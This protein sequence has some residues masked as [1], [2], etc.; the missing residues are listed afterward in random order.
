MESRLL[1]GLL[2]VAVAVKG[3]AAGWAQV[4]PLPLGCPAARVYA[5]LP[6]STISRLVEHVCVPPQ[7]EGSET[8]LERQLEREE[9]SKSRHPLLPGALQLETDETETW[10]VARMGHDHL[11]RLE[12]R[13]HDD[14]RLEDRARDTLAQTTWHGWIAPT[15]DAVPG[16]LCRNHSRIYAEELSNRLRPQLWALR[17]ADA[18]GKFPDGLLYGNTN[19]LGSWDGCRSV[20]VHLNASD[21]PDLAQLDFSGQV[22][23]A[24]ISSSPSVTD[25][26]SLVPALPI[27]A[28]LGLAPPAVRYAYCVPS[29]CDTED[30]S[31]SLTESLGGSGLTAT[32]SDC[33][34]EGESADLDAGDWALVVVLAL[35]A[36]TLLVCTALDVAA[37]HELRLPLPRRRSNPLPV[38]RGSVP[39]PPSRAGTLVRAFSLYDSVPRLLNTAKD[40][41]TIG[42]L[43]GIRFLTM[44]WIILGHIYAIGL[45]LLPVSNM[46]KL[47]E[48]IEPLPF[49]VIVN[50]MPA[51]DT[52]LVVS[53]AMVSLGLARE[54]GA[55]RPVGLRQLPALYL[56]RLLRLTPLYAAVIWFTA[57]LLRHIGSGTF[58][59]VN[60]AAFGIT[61]CQESWWH[62]L[63]YINNFFPN[64]E[65]V[66]I[67]QSWYLALDMQ[68]FLVAPLLV[69]PVLRW[70][71]AGWLPFGFI[72]LASVVIPGVITYVKDL[73]PTLLNLNRRATDPDVM[74][75]FTLL[76]Y[77][78]PWSRAAPYLIGLALGLMLVDPEPPK[79]PSRLVCGLLWALS[80]AVALLVVLGMWKYN[81]EPDSEWTPAVAV[82]YAALHRPAWGLCIAWV[83]WAC[84]KGRGGPVNALLSHPVW[85]PLS[86][87][88]YATYLTSIQLMVW[89]VSQAREPVAGS[90]LWLVFWFLADLVVNVA[91]AAVFSLAFEWPAA[92]L[93]KAARKRAAATKEPEP[94]NENPSNGDSMIRVLSLSRR[95]F[96]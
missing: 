57:T 5:H 58:T 81:S 60:F 13:V 25:G 55:G 35:V 39:P 50:A 11:K 23:S 89:Y 48:F 41:R 22:C 2:V 52:F 45:Y 32:V 73:P 88:T 10:N 79:R 75:D 70:P 65:T 69:L 54:A 83:I 20:R 9:H 63:L 92:A 67:D 44:A 16:E 56:H 59:T 7:V 38:Y 21:H 1:A 12:Y 6:E 8:E 91:I 78:A 18:S 96:Q 47:A 51:V 66:C 46:G 26:L 90:H 34:A 14:S 86:R 80:T 29:S 43:H 85:W 30:V 15:Q 36:V 82:S 95:D 71:R 68:L 27:L 24:V 31:V 37:A 87:L 40:P 64:D 3:G 53:G 17:M 4:H 19:L 84:A 49:Q 61:G 93:E 77:N 74:A 72:S 33:H 42:C 62:N 28:G 76:V 94:A